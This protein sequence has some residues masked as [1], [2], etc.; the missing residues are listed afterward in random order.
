M[1]A[2]V[3]TSHHMWVAEKSDQEQI[4]WMVDCV[5]LEVQLQFRS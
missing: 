4:W 1:K 2:A 3:D 5:E